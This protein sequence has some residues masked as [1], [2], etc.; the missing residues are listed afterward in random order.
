[1][2]SSAGLLQPPPVRMDSARSGERGARCARAS[3][4]NSTGDAVG[5]RGADEAAKGCEMGERGSV[6]EAGGELR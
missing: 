3:N 4:G 5:R 6:G 2:R 1:M